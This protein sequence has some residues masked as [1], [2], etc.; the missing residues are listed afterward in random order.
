MRR[1]LRAVLGVA[2]GLVARL[3]L[4]TLRMQLEVHPDLPADRPW[5]LSFF[6][7]TQWPLLAWKRRR[8][9]VVMVSLS[10]DGA[11]QARALGSLGFHVVR[12]SSSR[13]GVRALAAVVRAMRQGRDA[14]FA[15][16]GPRGPYGEPKPGALLA[17]KRAGAVLVPMGSAIRNGKVFDRAWDRFALAW[18][19]SRVAVVLGAQLDARGPHGEGQGADALSALGAAIRAA[20]A[21]AEAILAAGDADVVPL[22]GFSTAPERFPDVALNAENG[23]PVQRVGSP[24]ET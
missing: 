17:A 20:N 9:T 23:D 19:F 10:D 14:A 5:V 7:G 8:A 21:R 18:P 4:A 22:S 15:V 24:S 16:D 12:G 6:H 2:L 3:W 13:G 1:A 11:M